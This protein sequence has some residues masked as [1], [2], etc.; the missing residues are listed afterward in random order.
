MSNILTCAISKTSLQRKRYLRGREGRGG[1]EG[2]REGGKK[3]GREGGMNRG[4]QTRCT[5]MRTSLRSH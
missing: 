2:E 5:N 4:S 1:R 3:G